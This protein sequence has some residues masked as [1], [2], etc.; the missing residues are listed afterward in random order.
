MANPLVDLLQQGQSVWYDN[1]QRSL[2][3]SG[4]LQRLIAEDGLR[5]MTSNPAIF[6]KAISG[7]ADYAGALRTLAQRGQSPLQIYESLAVE[8]IQWAAD[9]L[10]PVY[11]ES[12]GQDGYISLEV[13][14]HLA[15]DTQGTVEEALRLADLVGRQNLMIKVPGTPAGVPA[16]EQLIGAGLNINITLLF[17]QQNYEQV[18][19]AYMAG[20][21]KL[22]AA[23]GDPASVAS[24]ASFFIS[25]IDSMVDGLL[26]EHLAQAD[27]EAQRLELQKLQGQVAIAN[28]KLT[29][30]RYGE[31]CASPRWQALKEQGAR[32]QRLL[33]ASTSTKNPD[34][35]DVLYVEEL[36]GPDTVN[37]MP[38]A[39]F[40]AFRD[41]GVVQ[42][43]LTTGVDEAQSVMDGL[44][45]T[46]ISMDEVTSRL[47]DDAV[48][49]FVEPFDN[50][51]TAIDEQCRAL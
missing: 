14:P 47:Q 26:D 21:E 1:M 22:A 2:I 10:L 18:A 27:N 12:N 39:T 37:T 43:T 41:H 13:S 7:S 49:L 15:H 28:A 46:G 3:T 44:A 42:Q 48:R 5:G 36:I 38:E 51:L 17:A 4:T 25:R 23:G 8:D 34:F 9:L 29:Y 32:P 19:Q 30:A 45:A 40:E 6:E 50:L 31:F 20:L 33:W 16:V 11:R 35:R 24:V